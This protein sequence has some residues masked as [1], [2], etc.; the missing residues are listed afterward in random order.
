MTVPDWLIP[1][2]VQFPIVVLVLVAVGIA[3]RWTDRRHDTVYEQLRA[4]LTKTRERTDA[5]IVRLQGLHRDEIARLEARAEDERKRLTARIREL[6]KK[7]GT[8]KSEEK[9]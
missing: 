5:E 3:I 4:E 2:L 7:L 9:S 8:E 6:E 1:V